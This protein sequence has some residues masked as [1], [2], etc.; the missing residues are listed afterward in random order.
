MLLALLDSENPNFRWRAA[1]A[2]ARS[3]DPI[4]APSVKELAQDGSP[5][6]RRQAV[7]VGFSLTDEAFDAVRPA[8]VSLL[9]DPEIAVRLEAAV[10]FAQQQ[11]RACARAL[12]ELMNHAED[13]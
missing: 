1:Y 5:E 6:V 4:L 10:Y 9:S 2:L 7:G 3:G 13:L 11:D 12:W 8:L